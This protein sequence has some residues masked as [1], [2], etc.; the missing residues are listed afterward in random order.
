MT[1]RI[2]PAMWG[3]EYRAMFEGL[4]LGTEAPRTSIIDNA[5]K[6]GYIARNKA[7]YRMIP[8]GEY[9]VA[10]TGPV[11]PQAVYAWASENKNVFFARLQKE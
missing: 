10:A 9:R 6:S 3:A 4:E 8:A 11:P 2:L 7:V 1:T 5:R